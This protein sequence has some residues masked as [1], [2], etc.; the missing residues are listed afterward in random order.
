[1]KKIIYE[2]EMLS[3][4][5]GVAYE[6]LN[7][8]SVVCYPF[9]LNHIVGTVVRW[10][11]KYR[12]TKPQEYTKALREKYDKGFQRGMAVGM[13]QALH[14]NESQIKIAVEELKKHLSKAKL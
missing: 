14:Q 10:W 8:M 6:N 12:N 11:W 13:E 3:R 9:P 4:G 5:Y 1:M 2:G 7:S